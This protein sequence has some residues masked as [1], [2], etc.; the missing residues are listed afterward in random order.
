[1]A[2]A[3]SS[4]R[5][6][7]RRSAAVT[8]PGHGQQGG[9]CR[10]G[11]HQAGCRRQRPGCGRARGDVHGDLP[12]RDPDVVEALTGPRRSGDPADA[13]RDPLRDRHR[14]GVVRETQP[15]RSGRPSSAATSANSGSMSSGRRS[16]ESSVG[17]CT[18]SQIALRPRQSGPRRPTP[19]K[20]QW[21]PVVLGTRPSV[22]GVKKP[23]RAMAPAQA[24][25]CGIRDVLRGIGYFDEVT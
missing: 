8:H 24:L 20:S 9:R 6:S 10:A 13:R 5:S 12:G 11:D 16:V 18:G 2:S 23:A 22:K 3:T 15:G 19:A 17:L 1:M 4:A 25:G 14:H 7:A 21:R